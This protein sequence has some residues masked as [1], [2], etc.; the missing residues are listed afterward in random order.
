MPTTTS[1]HLARRAIEVAESKIG[2][3]DLARRLGAPESIVRAWRDGRESMPPRK[4][5]L[6]IDVM[7]DVDP[8][9]KPE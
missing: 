4:Y 9:W 3:E 7:A 6:L 2:M 1:I 8:G 5:V